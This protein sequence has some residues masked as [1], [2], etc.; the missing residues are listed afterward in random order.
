MS[1]KNNKRSDLINLLLG[2]VLIVLLNVAS[3]YVFTRFDLT[4]EKRY[5]LAQSTKKMLKDLDDIVYFKV[6]LE[7]D[8]PQG[9]GDYKRLR[10]ETRI[11]LDEFR[12]YGG[13]KIQYEFI[14]PTESPDKKTQVAFE[15]QLYQEGLTPVQ[16]SFTGDDG[17]EVR[18]WLFPW[19]VASYKEKHINIPLFG[20]NSGKVENAINN[21]VEGLEYGLCNGIRKLEMT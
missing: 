10:D 1:Q 11:M 12:A 13:D 19:A 7:G 16:V 5:T 20:S 6:Y 14:D 17:S 8:F 18:R 15:K 2:L 4:A 21:A 9:A 3:Q